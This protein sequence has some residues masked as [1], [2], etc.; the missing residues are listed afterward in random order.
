MKHID[1]RAL[2]KEAL[3][4]RQK[5]IIKMIKNGNTAK[6]ISILTG[7]S[8]N[9]VYSLWN[10]YNQCT[11][12]KN[13]FAVKTRGNK[14]GTGRTLTLLQ[15]SKIKK[16]ML[17]KYPD[18]LKF[19]FALWT[20]SA[21]KLLIMKLFSI[22]MP[23]RTVGMYLQR[24]GFTPQK[25]IK[26]SYKRD[27]TKIDHWLNTE[28]PSI[29]SAAKHQNADIYWEDETS[30]ETG[31]IRGKGYAP[32]GKTPIVN[33]IEIKIKISML[34]AITNQGKVF[35]KLHSGTIDALKFLEFV[36]R[37]VWKKKRKIFLILDN[38]RVHHS[39]ILAT[40]LKN[41]IDKIELFFIPPYSP[42]LNPDERVNSDVKYGV[43]SRSPKRTEKDLSS[44][45][46]SHMNIL[47][48]NPSRIRKYFKD[49]VISYAG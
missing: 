13:F 12:K 24:W 48:K 26:R 49:E 17:E 10:R 1:G 23:V 46:D 34:S 20:R 22:D 18:Q 37:L 15:E 7:C 33:N 29:K 11:N 36:K 45:V 42:E 28:F 19:D 30:I 31:D 9:T 16:V 41:N 2:T 5:L 47:K 14:K 27:E 8:L 3:A 39:K 35:W 40:W 43:G 6:E 25:P 44:A 4:E 32:K 21:V 38:A